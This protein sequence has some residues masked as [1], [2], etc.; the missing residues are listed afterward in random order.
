MQKENLIRKSKGITL[1]ALIITIIVMLILVAVTITVSL[2][3]GLFTTANESTIK[4]D[5]EYEKEQLLMA[6]IGALKEDG[7]VDFNKLDNNLPEGFQN[8]GEGTYKSPTENVFKV[9]ENGS[10]TLEDDS[11]E[12]ESGEKEVL[13][14]GDKVK[15]NEGTGYTST[16]DSNFA[17]EDLEWRILDIE[18]DG[19]IE[20]V[21]TRATASTL[22]LSGKEGWLHA[23]EYLDTLC[24]DLYGNG[25]GATGAR[26]L[27][28]E[29][30][31]KLTN[32]RMVSDNNWCRYRYDTGKYHYYSYSSDY[33]PQTGEG[34]WSDEVRQSTRGGSVI[35]V[36]DGITLGSGNPSIKIKEKGQFSGRFDF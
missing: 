28:S 13:Q 24:D 10:I 7:K 27:K 1:I 6:A 19:T 34:T 26:C 21:S 25:T 16:I 12:E 31:V 9:N 23:E 5:L 11:G 33:N 4:M 22:T 17:M 3:G 2:N 14:I 15:Y 20:L 30:I 32:N 18:D 36:E 29:D 8:V 35:S